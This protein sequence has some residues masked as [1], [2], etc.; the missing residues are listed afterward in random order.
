MILRRN[1]AL[2][3]TLRKQITR[4]GGGRFPHKIKPM[5][6]DFENTREMRQIEDRNQIWLPSQLA[7]LN[8]S[9]SISIVKSLY[10]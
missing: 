8:K 10:K 6:N 7:F 2:A 1:Q 3:R 4:N 9:Y 5:V